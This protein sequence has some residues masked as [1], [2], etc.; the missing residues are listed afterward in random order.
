MNMNNAQTAVGI[1]ALTLTAGAAHAGAING[2]FA[3]S[4]S[5]SEVFQYYLDGTY[6]P[7]SFAGS[8]ATPGPVFSDASQGLVFPYLATYDDNTGDIFVGNF[9]GGTVR[10]DG[11]T[12][13]QTTVFLPGTQ[14]LDNAIASNGNLLMGTVNGIDEY[15]VNGTFVQTLIPAA[16]LP[17]GNGGN[18]LIEVAGSD[19]YVSNWNN[20]QVLRFDSAGNQDMA[21]AAATAGLQIQDIQFND[22]QLYISAFYGS[23][24]TN[25]VYMYDPTDNGFDLFALSADSGVGVG[26]HGFDFGPDGN[27]YVADAG[28]FITRYDGGTGSFIDVFAMTTSK[29]TDV[30]FRAGTVPAPGAAALL[31]LAGISATRRRR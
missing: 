4:D 30:N 26:P 28:G 14:S 23:T 20:T 9:N 10:I 6:V 18:A 15:T 29:L 16:S 8:G 11:T 21:F 31:G 27:L 12:G 17:G 3:M 24:A 22:G 7:G 5:T 13:L 19:I 2:L 25:G 1:F